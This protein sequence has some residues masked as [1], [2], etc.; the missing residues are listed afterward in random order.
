LK[1]D[2]LNPKLNLEKNKCDVNLSSNAKSQKKQ[3][4][5][6][7]NV[8]FKKEGKDLSTKMELIMVFT[9][10]NVATNFLSSIVCISVLTY[11]C[12]LM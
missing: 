9:N 1:F 10:S 4:N 2:L 7:M 6:L 5:N 12:T 8:K 3:K 11:V